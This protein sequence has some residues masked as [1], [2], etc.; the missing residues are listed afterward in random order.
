MRQVAAANSELLRR[1][2]AFQAIAQQW[3][4][5]VAFRFAHVSEQKTYPDNPQ[6]RC[7]PDWMLTP[8]ERYT[9]AQYQMRHRLFFWDEAANYGPILV[10][11]RPENHTTRLGMKPGRPHPVVCEMTFKPE[12]NKC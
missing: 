2:P 4:A 7:A 10:Q 9:L 11:I 1:V 5:S 12:S 6:A 8:E 3:I